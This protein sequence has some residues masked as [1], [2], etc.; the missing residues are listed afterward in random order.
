MES[1]KSLFS[2][3]VC[4]SLLGIVV[5]SF[6]S[7]NLPLFSALLGKKPSFVRTVGVQLLTTTSIITVSFMMDYIKQETEKEIQNICEI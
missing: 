4:G 2:A 3:Y 6:P 5:C 1:R 7:N